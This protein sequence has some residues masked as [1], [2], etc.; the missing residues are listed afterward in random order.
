MYT[1]FE[2]LSNTL[3]LIC[4]TGASKPLDECFNNTDVLSGLESQVAL[5]HNSNLMDPRRLSEFVNNTTSKRPKPILLWHFTSFTCR[6]FPPS[7][8]NSCFWKLARI[9]PIPKKINSLTF[10][11][12][13]LNHNDITTVFQNDTFNVT[14]IFR[15]RFTNYSR[16]YA[17]NTIYQMKREITTVYLVKNKQRLKWGVNKLLL[18]R[19]CDD[20]GCEVFPKIS[21]G[22]YYLDVLDGRNGTILKRQPIKSSSISY[23]TL[24]K[25]SFE[26]FQLDDRGR[27]LY[28]FL[29]PRSIKLRCSVTFPYNSNFMFVYKEINNSVFSDSFSTSFSLPNSFSIYLNYPQTVSNEIYS[30]QNIQVKTVHLGKWRMYD[31]TMQFIALYRKNASDQRETEEFFHFWNDSQEIHDAY[32]YILPYPDLE[33]LHKERSS[34]YEIY[35]CAKVICSKTRSKSET[36]YEKCNQTKKIIVVSE[37]LKGFTEMLFSPLTTDLVLHDT[38]QFNMNDCREWDYELLVEYENVLSAIYENS[39]TITE[40]TPGGFYKFICSAFF[41]ETGDIWSTNVTY[42][43]H[44]E[45]HNF[46]IYPNNTKIA[47]GANV[48]CSAEGFPTPNVSWVVQSMIHNDFFLLNGNSF[49]VKNNLFHGSFHLICVGDNFIRMTEVQ[50]TKMFTFDYK[51]DVENKQEKSFFSMLM[52]M[53]AIIFLAILMFLATG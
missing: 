21:G 8:C 13:T 24:I 36:L 52:L 40:N 7:R 3:L 28:D 33:R 31:G 23:S 32:N 2:L 35:V 48:S 15:N 12:T 29:E 14:C 19:P 46:K 38:F 51:V 27:I 17:Y 10:R 11:K 53:I 26:T 5:E 45:A 25:I 37:C 34:E 4:F 47:L 39:F 22:R 30:Y 9:T 50:K 41:I 44:K 6:F 16:V 1:F 42:R 49:I 43:V 18:V 20:I